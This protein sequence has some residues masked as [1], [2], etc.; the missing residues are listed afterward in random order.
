MKLPRLIH[1]ALPGMIGSLLLNHSLLAQES[2]D[3]R[4]QPQ[5]AAAE[6]ASLGIALTAEW[7]EVEL[8]ALPA[9]LHRHGGDADSSAFHAEVEKLITADKAKRIEVVYGRLTPGERAS[10][11]SVEEV[12]YPT[13]Y[14]PPE[15]PNV[16]TLRDT[17]SAKVPRTA[18]NPTA[19]E[20][21]LTGVHIEVDP[22]IEEDSGTIRLSLAPEHVEFIERDYH[23][24]EAAAKGG[25]HEQAAL[26]MPRFYTMRVTTTIRLKPG[27]SALVGT[28]KPYEAER[29][30]Q[31]LLLFVHARMIQPAQEVLEARE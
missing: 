21:R 6:T 14:D 20:T 10:I 19:F 31:R 18:A 8:A 25:D 24:P 30:Q 1:F 15:I 17:D 29:H 4:E 2:P 28:F 12:I 9:L 11:Q 5:V 22:S 27:T 26:W 13:E 16:I 3:A 23:V 7:I